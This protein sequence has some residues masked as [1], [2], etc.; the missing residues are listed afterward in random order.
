MVNQ[1]YRTARDEEA[2]DVEYIDPPA[3]KVR[4][5]EQR[6][7]GRSSGVGVLSVEDFEIEE[8]STVIEVEQL[9]GRVLK[10]S[11]TYDPSAMTER[12]T[13]DI[14]DM[15][16]DGDPLS[17]AELFC[18]TVTSWEFMGPL[19]AKVYAR[20]ER[21]RVVRDDNGR[22]IQERFEVVPAGQPIPIDPEVL[23][24]LPNAIVLGIWRAIG[25]EVSGDPK[26]NRHSRRASRRR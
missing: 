12:A 16:E 2:D 10:M 21:G 4:E 1:R 9:S 20:D 13:Q 25:K 5:I 26:P 22:P 24:Y 19:T 6:R 14:Q 7:S 23:Q 17:M 18:T 11:L 8:R 15:A 3:E